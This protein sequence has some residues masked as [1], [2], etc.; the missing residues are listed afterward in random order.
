M[1]LSEHEVLEV[2]R[3]PVCAVCQL[4]A[5]AGRAYLAGVIEGGIND[6]ETRADWRRR[7]GLCPHHW[8]VAR[9]LEAPALPLAILSED[10]LEEG[11]KG[12]LPRPPRCP[13]CA[14]EAR[15][16]ARYLAAIVA[17][18]EPRL[19]AALEAGKGFLCLDHLA[20]LPEGP[21]QARFRARLKEILADLKTFQRKYDYRFAKEP[22]GRERDAWLRAVRAL[23]GAV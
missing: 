12:H 4:T 10:L 20:R 23:G 8:V 13:A 5:R 18:P 7:G 14:V 15:A 9:G 11:L 22:M 3:E 21:K 1:H 19:F 2:L 17:L 6:P 16:E